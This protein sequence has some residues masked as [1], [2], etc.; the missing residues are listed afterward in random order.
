[1][2]RTR[3]GLREPQKEDGDELF[4][5]GVLAG[6]LI[7]LVLGAIGNVITGLVLGGLV[8]FLGVFQ[9]IYYLNKANQFEA[10]RQTYEASRS[11]AIGQLQSLSKDAERQE[12]TISS[13]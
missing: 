7:V 6:L 1:M 11:K 12:I 10:A 8:L 3:H 5:V 13:S 2:V 9:G 4:I